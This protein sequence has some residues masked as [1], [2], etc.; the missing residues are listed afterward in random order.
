MKKHRFPL[1]LLLVLLTFV[2]TG[3]G[4][5]VTQQDTAIL[6]ETITPERGDLS[7]SSRFVGK[8]SPTE[9]V[10]ILPMVSA[11]VE[12]VCVQVGDTISEGQVLARLDDEAAQLQL[13]SALL[14]LESAQLTAEQTTGSSWQLQ[15]LSTDASIQQLQDTIADYQRQLADAKEQLEDLEDDEDDYD[16]ALDDA[17][18]AYTQ[19]VTAYNTALAYKAQLG[20]TLESIGATTS[21][22]LYTQAMEEFLSSG[23][24]SSYDSLESCLAD[25]D[26]ASLALYPA[27]LCQKTLSDAGLTVES[28]TDA[29]IQLLSNQADIAAQAYS[30]ASSAV[31]TI[32]SGKEQL[33][34]A[35]ESYET[36][37][38]TYQKQLATAMASRDI[39]N[40]EVLS[41]TEAMLNT[42]VN[43]ANVG[44]RSARMS[45]NYYTL[46]SPINGTVTAVSLD[47]HGL[48]SP[49]YAAFTIS[50][51]DAMTITFDVSEAVRNT[52]MVGEKIQ[53][54]RSGDT[55]NGTIT[56]I[57]NA[58]N[59]MTGLFSVEAVVAANGQQ[60]PSGVTATVTA[61]TY[62]SYDALLLPY[63][64][65]YWQ[66]GQAYV[67]C[68]EDGKAV[69]TMIQTDVYN[70]DTIAVISG[71]NESDQVIS[72]WSPRLRD[73]IEITL[74]E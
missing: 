10:S 22:G 9:E 63:D 12:E 58:V 71:L 74:G 15:S 30:G 52:L 62:T 43:A 38:E 60:L 19:A 50:A 23:L 65:V 70:E 28:L 49:G 39:T 67:Y 2:L 26:T 34:T 57:G 18:K 47:E 73:G 21:T 41:E 35:I 17:E 16:D 45:L 66:E 36:A 4:Q 32:S 37:I 14:S 27:M 31:P 11:E 33:E 48:T 25:L 55:W 59:P 5:E 7:I 68:V 13:N 56:Q 44:V 1:L 42:S 8:V 40:N 64:A 46:T 20:P 61:D 54:E 53:V 72:T 51:I 6:V 29:N 69:K 24:S 3:C